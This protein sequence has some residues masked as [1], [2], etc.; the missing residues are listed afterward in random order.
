MRVCKIEGFKVIMEDAKK[1][2]ISIES[3]LQK[4]E[5]KTNTKFGEEWFEEIKLLAKLLKME[6]KN[7]RSL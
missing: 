7:R 4:Y 3:S 6:V 5:Q 1:R 2:L